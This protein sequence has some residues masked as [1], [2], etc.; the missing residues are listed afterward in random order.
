MVEVDLTLAQADSSR[1]TI[2]RLL[3]RVDARYA[4][5]FRRTKWAVGNALRRDLRNTRPLPDNANMWLAKSNEMAALFQS[6]KRDSPG[7]E[8]SAE[9]IQVGRPKAQDEMLVLDFRRGS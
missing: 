2:R 9:R 1:Q 4:I 5:P 6:T 7:P 8:Y 3:H